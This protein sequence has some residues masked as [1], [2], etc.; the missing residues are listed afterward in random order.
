MCTYPFSVA[1]VGFEVVVGVSLWV[2][3][4][5]CIS[6]VIPEV[7]NCIILSYKEVKK[8]IS[9]QLVNVQESTGT[10]SILLR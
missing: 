7:C 10:M 3:G 2:G 4:E 1:Q 8:K 9:D 5:P 6:E